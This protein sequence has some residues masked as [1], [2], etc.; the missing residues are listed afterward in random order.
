MKYRAKN[1]SAVFVSVDLAFES[2]QDFFAEAFEAQ[3]DFLAEALEQDFLESLLVH[4]FLSHF[5]SSSQGEAEIVVKPTKLN[6]AI[7]NNN[8]FIVIEV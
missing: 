4:S 5:L 3:Q 8:F 6:N 2:L 1:Y 7:D